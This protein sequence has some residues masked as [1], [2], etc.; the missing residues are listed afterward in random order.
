[1]TERFP[2]PTCRLCG[3]REYQHARQHEGEWVYYCPVC[4]EYD[5]ASEKILTEKAS[6]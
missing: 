6:K 1:M 4:G 2:K 5:A 3:C